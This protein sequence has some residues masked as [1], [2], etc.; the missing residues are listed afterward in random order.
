MNRVLP[1]P[2]VCLFRRDTSV[3]KP[4][5]V[6]EL[7]GAVRKTAPREYG[8]RIDDLSEP[9]RRPSRLVERSL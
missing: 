1:S 9:S 8:D 4:S 3:V 7:V 5:L 2:A 6:H